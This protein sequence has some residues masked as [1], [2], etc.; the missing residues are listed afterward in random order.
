MKV[1]NNLGSTYSVYHENL[2]NISSG[3]PIQN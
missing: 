3:Q 2:E 1:R